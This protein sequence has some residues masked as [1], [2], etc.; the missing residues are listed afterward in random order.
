MSTKMSSTPSTL[1]RKVKKF[2]TSMTLWWENSYTT[3]TDPATVDVEVIIYYDDTSTPCGFELYDVESGGEDFYADGGLWFTG[4]ALTEYDGV[5]TL[6][7]AIVDIIKEEG[8]S[9]DL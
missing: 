7:D 5:F 9:I 3:L 6:P 8:Y 4:N 1:P 2:I